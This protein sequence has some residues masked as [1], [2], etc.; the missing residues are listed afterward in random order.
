[1]QHQWVFNMQHQ[2]QHQQHQWV[3]AASAPVGLPLRIFYFTHFLIKIYF[4]EEN[5]FFMGNLKQRVGFVAILC[6]ATLSIGKAF[7][8]CSYFENS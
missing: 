1:M 8:F 5:R 3:Y 6:H 2:W 7:Y 4:F